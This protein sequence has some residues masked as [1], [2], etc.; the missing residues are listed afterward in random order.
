MELLLNLSFLLDS[1]DTFGHSLHWS[2]LHIPTESSHNLSSGGSRIF[3][4]GGH[5][6]A[7][8]SARLRA[9]NFFSRLWLITPF[10]GKLHP[11][12]DYSQSA[13]NLQTVM[14][15]CNSYKW[16]HQKGGGGGGMCLKCPLLDPPL[17]SIQSSLNKHQIRL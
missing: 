8:L 17:L 3:R 10:L 5:I 16:P 14:H 4:K 15:H 1:G 13:A 12:D 7:G 9:K 11:L 2:V 6:D